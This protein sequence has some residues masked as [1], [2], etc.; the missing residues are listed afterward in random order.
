MLGALAAGIYT[1]VEE[2]PCLEKYCR[3][4]EPKQDN[5]NFYANHSTIYRQLYPSLKELMKLQHELR[6]TVK[7]K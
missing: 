5:V 3:I 6:Q 2:V 1:K 7:V 4:V